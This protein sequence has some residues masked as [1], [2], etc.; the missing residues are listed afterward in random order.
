VVANK[1][2]RLEAELK[3]DAVFIDGGYGT[4]IVSAGKTLGREWQLVCVRR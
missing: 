1:L 2:M 4:G 3:V